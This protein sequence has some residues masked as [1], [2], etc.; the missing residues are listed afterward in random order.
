MPEFI[1][2]ARASDVHPGWIKLVVLSGKTI[3]LANVRGVFYAVDD[4]CPHANGSMVTGMLDGESIICPWHGSRFNLRTGGVEM[5]PATKG[6]ATY[7]VLVENDE[8]KLAKP[9]T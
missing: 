8:V 7:Q 3:A 6:I 2:V 5:S 4:L 9:G 1:T